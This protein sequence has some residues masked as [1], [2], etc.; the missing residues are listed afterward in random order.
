M[1]REHVWGWTATLSDAFAA[2]LSVVF[3]NLL[4]SAVHCG[5]D[6]GFLEGWAMQSAF[7]MQGP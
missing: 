4:S 6:P 5:L 7:P 3:L 1:G 2:V